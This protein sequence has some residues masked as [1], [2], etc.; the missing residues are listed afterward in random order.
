MSNVKCY[1]CHK[2]GHYV[3]QCPNKKKGRKEAQPKVAASTKAQADEFAKK[4]EQTKFLLVSQTSLNTISVGACV[5]DSGTTCHMTG[6]RDLFKSFIESD[7]N[8]HVE[9]GM[10]TKHAMKGSGIVP[11]RMESRGV[12]RVM[13]VLWVLELRSV[14]SVSTI[15]NK[16]FDITFQ[17]GHALIKP[18]GSSSDTTTVLGVRAVKIIKKY[19][20]KCFSSPRCLGVGKCLMWTLVI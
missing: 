2:F 20:G 19:L 5:I 15:E 12:L 14:L 3:G 13:N 9:L 7:S 17:D 18:R 1:A 16:R 4:F 11:F 10:G 6:A 8:V